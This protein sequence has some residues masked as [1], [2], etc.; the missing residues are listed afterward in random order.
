MW[1]AE[2][3]KKSAQKL[4]L[5]TLKVKGNKKSRIK[6]WKIFQVFLLLMRMKKI[7]EIEIVRYNPSYEN[8]LTNG[9]VDHRKDDGLTNKGY[10]SSSK[11]WKSILINNLLTPINVFSIIFLGLVIYSKLYL[12]FIFPGL[13]LLN[14]LLEILFDIVKKNKADKV[15][16]SYTKEETVVRSGATTKVDS[17]EIV[18]DDIVYILMELA[19]GEISDVVG[20]RFQ[21]GVYA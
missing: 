4:S 12:G 7:D 3:L 19:K 20:P 21:R 9:Q 1:W 15:L 14:V 10:F 5:I 13:I 6:T 11:S 17:Q 2:F 18:L 8:G 16:S